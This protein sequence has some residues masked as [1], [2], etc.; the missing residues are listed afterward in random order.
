M[1]SLGLKPINTNGQKNSTV[2]VIEQEQ[3]PASPAT[4][5][6]HTKNLNCHIIA[7]LGCTTKINPDVIKK[8]LESTLLNHPRFSSIPDTETPMKGGVGVE[9]SPKRLVHTTVSLDD[10]KIVKNALN[11]TIN[12]VVMGMAQAGFSRYLNRRYGNKNGKGSSKTNNL[13]K[14]IRLRG[15]I[16]FNI[17]PSTGIKALAEMM[18]KKSKARWGNKIG[19]VLT[20]LPISLPDNPLDYIRQAKT[21]IDRKK[22]SLESR[23]SFSAAKLT[24][25]IF[26]SKVA[27]K[28][29]RRI[30]SSTT[31]LIS[32]VVGPQEEITFYGHKLAYVAPTTFGLPYA[33]TIHFQSYCN[34]MTIS[35]AVDPQVIPDPYQLCDD[36]QDSLQMFKEAVTKQDMV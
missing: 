16:V 15:S 35:M 4:R 6:F 9:H 10:M 13:P 24:Q 25:D 3:V 20:R 18:E 26:G 33:V 12:D 23:F 17:R 14:N 2:V 8:G 29:T 11:L 21:I 5:L 36:L 27:A 28:V 19:Y 31:V 1:G 22:L 7:I 30:L 34:K 32:N